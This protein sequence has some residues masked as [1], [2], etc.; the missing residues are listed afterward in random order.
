MARLEEL[1]GRHHVA[2]R[3]SKMYVPSYFSQS[4]TE[5]PSDVWRRLFPIPYWDQIQAR[6][7]E[8]KLDP[9]LVAGL[10]R[11][12]SEFNPGAQ[13]RSNARG[14]MQLLP[15]TA[16]LVAR[17]APDARSRRYSVSNL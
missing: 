8:S 11:Q 12:E 9:F 13:S 1:R 6:A 10:I 17:K 5:L 15:S 2:L 7:A 4:I 3:L 14:L 16:K